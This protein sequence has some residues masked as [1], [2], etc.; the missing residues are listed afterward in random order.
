[1]DIATL[2]EEARA[3]EQKGRAADALALYRKALARLEGTQEI[4]R[5]LPLYVKAGDLNLKLGDGKTAITMYERAAKRY[6]QYG[7]GKSVLALCAKILR[8]SPNRTQV[9]LA[10]ARL[11]VERGHVAEAAKVLAGYAE[12]VKLGKTRQ[13]I[14]RL[15]KGDP[16]QVRPVLEM[17]LEVAGRA[18]AQL[19]T[20]DQQPAAT[21]EPRTAGQREV[22]KSDAGAPGT[23]TKVIAT[24]KPGAA[25]AD[26][27]PSASGTN[28]PG[29]HE[30][31]PHGVGEVEAVVHPKESEGE[32]ESEPEEAQRPWFT[33][34]P[35]L[36]GDET[37]AVSPL[38]VPRLPEELAESREDEE[39][40]AAEPVE[41]TRDVTPA[42]GVGGLYRPEP[43]GKPSG[44][45]FSPTIEPPLPQDPVRR[46]QEHEADVV[47]PRA[48]DRPQSAAGSPRQQI[49]RS[50]PRPQVTFTA[51]KPKRS[52]RGWLW[53]ALGVIVVAGGSAG[54]VMAGVVGG[55]GGDDRSLGEQT[56]RPSDPQPRDS[57]ALRS[58]AEDTGSVA[59]G[60]DRTS[61]APTNPVAVPAEQRVSEV[62]D[63][64]ATNPRPLGLPSQPTVSRARTVPSV[65]IDTGVGRQQ[66]VSDAPAAARPD[67]VEPALPDLPPGVTI[68]A[69]IIVIRGLAIE[70]VTEFPGGGHRVVQL[71]DS[72]E[73][74]VLTAIPVAADAADSAESGVVTVRAMPGA[75]TVGSV[76]HAGHLV[77]AQG[78]IAANT[79]TMLLGRLAEIRP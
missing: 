18:E 76:R 59:G 15:V 48:R 23:K 38:E 73:R 62:L 66:P 4:W 54:L 79:L 36:P 3:L 46:P 10:F 50:G 28:A 9:Y 35:E 24:P 16:E 41:V 61:P 60:R 39:L 17:L 22:G 19:K 30:K 56:A 44:L 65:P 20:A 7:S 26:R 45:D 64:G 71:L 72:G 8:V 11:M 63:T 52:R 47:A 34:G 57:T 6:A 25:R 69:P 14:Q 70:S 42:P 32:V 53:A 68:T 55:G 67:S 78:M 58:A 21:D 49:T 75:S 27:P 5:E 40:Q 74:L 1:M 13:V 12:L 2:K 43:P 29:T 31:V 33:T 77:D 37:P 51:H